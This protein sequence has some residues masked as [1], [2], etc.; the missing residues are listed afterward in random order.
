[1][2]GLLV[3]SAPAWPAAPADAF[4]EAVR[5]WFDAPGDAGERLQA[6][7]AVYPEDDDVAWWLARVR[8]DQGREADAL[9]LL[10]GRSGRKVPPHRFAW[11]RAL[12]LAPSQPALAR[13]EL[14]PVLRSPALATDPER[15]DVLALGARLAWD[16]RDEADALAY[17]RAAG[18]TLPGFGAWTRRTGATPLRIEVDG[19]VHVVTAGGLVVRGE[20]ACVPTRG[21][22]TPVEVPGP[23]LARA[24]GGACL[25]AAGARA[26]L[27]PT[28]GGWGYLAL[29]APEGRGIFTIPRCG[30]PPHL[31]RRT[32]G[33]GAVS[34]PAWLGDT[35]LWVQGGSAYGDGLEDKLWE[36]TEVVRLAAG[37]DGV[38]V[39]AWE[40]GAPR[41]RV[42][43]TLESPLIPLFAED[44][45]VTR[46][47]W[48][49]SPPAAA[50]P[51]SP[52]P[53][54]ARP[55]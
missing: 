26:D 33:D 14:A 50:A 49:P 43:A 9:A 21:A 2:A 16:A 45:P 19:R 42:A 52:P 1:M 15:L 35:L 7:H 4:A 13:V 34:S 24:G 54:P 10:A 17:V 46:A 5:G 36:G 41:L 18:G 8:I 53:P 31:E 12:A 28:P 3:A 27:A 39:I 32:T 55:R 47:E 6:L 37:P 23:E 25:A 48:C 44:P 38:L 51:G 29:D 40:A 20:G 30:A 22:D 11:L